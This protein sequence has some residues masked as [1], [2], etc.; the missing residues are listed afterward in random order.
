[1]VTSDSETLEEGIAR[2]T[3]EEKQ[4][5]LK[6][7]E[8]LWDLAAITAAS[9]IYQ[10]L[11]GP[12]PHQLVSLDIVASVSYDIADALMIERRKRLKEP[13]KF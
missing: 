5:F 4:Q 7:E 6:N 2:I 3:K 9:S 13:R 1:M 11:A 8:K 12:S 10:T